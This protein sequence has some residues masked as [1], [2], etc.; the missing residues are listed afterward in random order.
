MN[1]M[2]HTAW[3]EYLAVASGIISVWFSKKEI[4]WVYPVGLINTAIYVYISMMGHLPG[5][6][7][8]NIYYTAMG[9]A[10]WYLWMRKDPG[11]RPVLQISFSSRRERMFQ[12][13]FFV[14]LYVILFLSISLFRAAFFEGAIPWADAL[15]AASAFTAMWLMTKKKMEHWYWWIVTNVVSIPLY[16]V[17]HYVFS[18]AYYLVLL[19]MAFSGL[20][21]WKS[22]YRNT[23]HAN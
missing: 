15:A 17:K 9:I 23:A 1:D 10:G 14:I 11:S 5:E 21:A 22:K 16:F 13:I 4:F 6:A 18:S 8:V 7:I 19:I 20:A 3:Y 2:L 12:L